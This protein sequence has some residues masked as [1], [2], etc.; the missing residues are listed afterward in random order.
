MTAAAVLW[1]D[2][3]R[4]E[5]CGAFPVTDEFSLSDRGKEDAVG[6]RYVQLYES[7][8]LRAY[9]GRVTP[10][11][12][13]LRDVADD[14]QGQR[15]VACGTDRFRR[16]EAEGVMVD[17]NLRWPMVYRGMG[18]SSTADGSSDVRSFQKAVLDRWLRPVPGRLMI[19]AIAESS[20]IRDQLGNPAIE[21]ARQRGRIDP[22][23]AAVI[24]CGLADRMR[25]RPTQGYAAYRVLNR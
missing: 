2:T 16:E 15:V 12:E 8:E 22:L 19:H 10:V 3:G 9:R 20:V 17:A 18:K 14:L 4:M 7:D 5:V 6:Q 24:A 1:P 11:Q 23:S 21:K 25:S 13:F